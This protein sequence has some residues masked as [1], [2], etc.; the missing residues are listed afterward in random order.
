MAWALSRRSFIA[1]IIASGAA[2]VYAGV[3][4]AGGWRSGLYYYALCGTWVFLASEPSKLKNRL[5][6][7]AVGFIAAAILLF[8]P[9]MDFRHNLNAGMT[10]SE[11][12]MAVIEGRQGDERDLAEKFHKIVRRFNGID[13]YMTASYGSEDHKLGFMSL[14]NGAASN[15]F[16]FGILGTPEEAVTTQ[17]ITLWGS[18]SIALGDQWLAFAGLIAGAV[19]GGL[20][21]F[22]R[23][24]FH[25]PVMRSVY[26]STVTITLLSVFMGNGAF[27]L[28]SKELLIGFSV[29]MLFKFVAASQPA[30]PTYYP[31]GQMQY[32]QS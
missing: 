29:T 28:Y 6:P 18:I 22:C 27:M 4:M 16:T 31:Q 23:R 1:L 24:W 15:F 12:F 14:F 5:K 30:P 10:Q 21:I 13:L 25:T 26:E 9:V 17:G 7:F 11:A 3:E 20:P 19:V 8:V 32:P 2:L